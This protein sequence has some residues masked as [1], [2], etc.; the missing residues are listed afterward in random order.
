M[1]KGDHMAHLKYHLPILWFHKS[2]GG[3]P[4]MGSD[5]NRKS[6]VNLRINYLNDDVELTHDLEP[7][8]LIG[9]R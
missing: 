4:E 2:L 1:D 7:R 8:I 6:T 5:C 9:A 3:F